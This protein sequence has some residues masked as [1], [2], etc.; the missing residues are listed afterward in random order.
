[1]RNRFDKLIEDSLCWHSPEVLY[2][3]KQR[4]FLELLIIDKAHRLSLKCL[5]TITDFSEKHKLGIVFLCTPGFDRRIRN[6]EQINNRV[7]FYHTFSKP[8]IEELRA[9]LEA[10]WQAQQIEIQDSAVAML[11]SIT[12]A[13]IRKLVNINAEISRVCALNSVS[14][15]TPDLVELASKTKFT[16][17]NN[18]TQRK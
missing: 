16:T 15:I 3:T 2:N 6:Y 14:I 9:I 17:P 4:R 18:R 11:E 10:R 1:L 5:E 7:G 13:N 12:D 8:R